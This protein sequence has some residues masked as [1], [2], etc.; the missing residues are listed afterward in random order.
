MEH[1]DVH[2]YSFTLIYNRKESE[3]LP[4]CTTQLFSKEWRSLIPSY[5]FKSVANTTVAIS[6]ASK[7]ILKIINICQTC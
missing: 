1:P 4:Y 7:K 6:S 3:K 2:A 5:C